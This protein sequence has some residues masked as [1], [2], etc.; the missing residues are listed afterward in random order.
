VLPLVTAPQH[1]GTAK[2]RVVRSRLAVATGMASF[3]TSGSRDRSSSTVVRRLA[4]YAGS[5]PARVGLR[6]TSAGDSGVLHL[7]RHFADD[8]PYWHQF[9]AVPRLE[10]TEDER[11]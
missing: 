11:P 7:P 8:R 9:P 2:M 1:A 10:C 6:V 5:L 3:T 4:V